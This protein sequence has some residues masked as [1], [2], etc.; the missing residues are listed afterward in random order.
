[1]DEIERQL[2]AHL[3]DEAARAPGASADVTAGVRSR[4]RR[5]RTVRAAATSVG[6]VAA[7][8]VLGVAAW[9]LTGTAAPEPAGPA[10]HSPT[11]EATASSEAAAS[12][13]ASSGPSV[14]PSL[15]NGD[16]PALADMPEVDDALDPTLVPDYPEAYVME[17]W[18]WDEVGPGWGIG[19]VAALYYPP[20]YEY[21][22]QLPPAVLYL[23]SPEG[24]YFEVAQLP[25][26]WWDDTRVVSWDEAGGGV[27]LWSRDG[28]ARYDLRTGELEE[29]EF[30]IG[31]EPA[32]AETFIAADADGNELWEARND[33]GGGYYRWSADEGWAK[34]STWEDAPSA[35]GPSQWPGVTSSA[36]D[37]TGSR[38]L[39]TTSSADQPD[40]LL[41]DE[42]VVYDVSDDTTVVYPVTQD[43]AI[44]EVYSPW[45]V[46]DSTIAFDG[47]L[48]ENPASL[49][50]SLEAPLSFAEDAGLTPPETDALP[51]A[52]DVYYGEA[53]PAATT[54]QECG[55]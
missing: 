34:A 49:V 44:G 10:S 33:N 6:A 4:V 12:A 15:A 1:M 42:V 46:D 37:A 48:H 41:P 54:A 20:T 23:H 50:A 16:L 45:W 8:G 27:R 2:S 36:L 24:V 31:G 5:R 47:Y 30:S 21:E 32:E 18:I 13:T 9:G 14:A 43:D 11:P 35:M 53:T 26:G 52:V 17:D 25:A 7:V 28:G 51:V 3:G 19:V 40:G 29:V 39:L 22:G 55:C 38:V